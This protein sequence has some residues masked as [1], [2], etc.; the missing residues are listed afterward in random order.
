[1][2][3]LQKDPLCETPEDLERL[4]LPKG[5]PGFPQVSLET[6][7]GLRRK[8]IVDET[9]SD[10]Q[11]VGDNKPVVLLLSG[12]ET[13]TVWGR[14]SELLRTKEYPFA[15]FQLPGF[16]GDPND[17]NKFTSD[18]LLVALKQYVLDLK[19]RVGGERLPVYVVGHSMGANLAILF[20]AEKDFLAQNGIEVRGIDLLAP[21]LDTKIWKMDLTKPFFNHA[22]R[23]QALTVCRG[24]SCV[25]ETLQKENPS[26]KLGLTICRGV[27]PIIGTV[28]PFIG[29][30][31]SIDEYRSR[32]A[33]SSH[34]ESEHVKN[35]V[36]LIPKLPVK[37]ACE[38]RVQAIRAREALSKVEAHVNVIEAKH[39]VLVSPMTQ[40]E[41][42][43]LPN[44]GERRVF[45]NSGHILPEDTEAEDVFKL[46]WE[47]IL[48]TR[49]P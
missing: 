31:I 27:V 44:R 43:N 26:R 11:N 1:M 16:T 48:Q 32:S 36:F 19:A 34:K 30:N 4:K 20:A 29:K 3:Q 23:E 17:V 12:Y 38:Y 37:F 22:P 2:H 39:D 21:A 40:A 8:A 18:N 9:C 46:L 10:L 47:H 7:S 5:L 15:Q 14:F 41:F 35:D 45:E 24:L 33:E 28:L 25:E 13:R 6:L 42:E 49:N